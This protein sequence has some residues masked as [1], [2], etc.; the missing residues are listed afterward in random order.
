MYW[1]LQ[2]LFSGTLRSNLDPFN[3]FDDAGLWNTLERSYLVD[4]V[5]PQDRTEEGEPEPAS[6]GRF[7]FDTM[8]ED[9]ENNLTVGQYSL[10]SLARAL[11]IQ[12]C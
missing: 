10:V 3:Q 1:D 6:S 4:N 9:D 8:V 5:K 2:L 7:T 11:R 12:M